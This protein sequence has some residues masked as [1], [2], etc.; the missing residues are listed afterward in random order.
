VAQASDSEDDDDDSVE[1]DG[2]GS[3]DD[4]EDSDLETYAQHGLS[5][6]EPGLYLAASK[7]GYRS[8]AFG[9]VAL[10]KLLQ[11]CLSPGFFFG[12]TISIVFSTA[13]AAKQ[14]RRRSSPRSVLEALE[15]WRM[16]GDIPVAIYS[17]AWESG[18]RQ[19]SIPPRPPA[20]STPRPLLWCCRDVLCR[21]NLGTTVTR[22]PCWLYC[23]AGRRCP[24]TPWRSS[25]APSTRSWSS[26]SRFRTC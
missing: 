22:P 23:A 12:E 1:M 20:R 19:N 10:I 6:A 17:P 7:C 3:D 15:C 13:E 18:H 25:S 26:S 8:F 5:S 21:G 4:D 16:E 14:R 11:V 24:R 2:H 9:G